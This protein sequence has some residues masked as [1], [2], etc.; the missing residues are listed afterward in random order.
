LDPPPNSHVFE[1][2]TEALYIYINT[3]ICLI[4]KCNIVPILK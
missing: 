3:Y 4:E 1:Y 2:T